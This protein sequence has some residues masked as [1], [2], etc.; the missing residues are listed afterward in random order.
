V[1]E[2][3]CHA[4]ATKPAQELD[5]NPIRS[6]SGHRFSSAEALRFVRVAQNGERYVPH[7]YRDGLFR[8]ADPAL[9]RTKHHAANQIAIR[10]EEIASYLA[11]GFLLRMHGEETKQ[12]NLI[13]ASE[14]T[15]MD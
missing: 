4:T 5:V 1:T 12:V 15:L 9:G 3:W 8:V 7:R 13:S 14:I 11:R 2:F 10:A 6:G